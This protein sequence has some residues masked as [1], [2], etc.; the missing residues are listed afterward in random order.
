[1]ADD[2]WGLLARASPLAGGGA[3][4]GDSAVAGL[5]RGISVSIEEDVTGPSLGVVLAEAFLLGFLGGGGGRS[6]ADPGE[7]LLGDSGD[8][9]GEAGEVKVV[10]TGA[11]DSPF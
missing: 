5:R 8:A 3:V 10:T 2:S 9:A 11:R 1:M 4:T 6:L 7:N